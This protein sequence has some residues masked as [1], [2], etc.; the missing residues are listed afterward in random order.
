MHYD[1]ERVRGITSLVRQ[2]FRQRC[3]LNVPLY[4]MS[5]KPK[6]PSDLGLVRSCWLILCALPAHRK[7]SNSLLICLR[8]DPKICIGR[9]WKTYRSCRSTFILN[10]LFLPNHKSKQEDHMVRSRLIC[11]GNWEKLAAKMSSTASVRET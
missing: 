10:T 4:D 5:S 7:F 8:K 2:S 3:R 11:A 9:V 1:C 6:P